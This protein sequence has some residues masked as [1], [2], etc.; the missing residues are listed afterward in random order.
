M[1]ATI[2]L[3]TPITAHDA[4]VTELTLREPTTAD[5]IEIGAPMLIVM[6]DDDSAGVRIQPKAIARYISKLAGIPPS[7]VS[8]LALNDFQACSKAVMGF[9]GEN[10]AAT[11]QSSATASST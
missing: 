11:S 6:G 1:S 5:Y 8:A 3:S 7:S 4:Q 9:F 10:E 2:K